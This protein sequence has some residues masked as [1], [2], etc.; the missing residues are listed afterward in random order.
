MANLFNTYLEKGPL[1][2]YMDFLESR[3]NSRIQEDTNTKRRYNLE[4]GLY[5]L[6]VLKVLLSFFE[7]K[8]FSIYNFS[9]DYVVDQNVGITIEG[10]P[11]G[12]NGYCRI[13]SSKDRVFKYFSY[14]PDVL[15]NNIYRAHTPFTTKDLGIV[16]FVNVIANNLKNKLHE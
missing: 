8:L 10:G 16:E 7:K 14:T 5:N 2:G 4:I 12:K 6:I 3:L 1:L 11:L 13:E 15:G 9:I